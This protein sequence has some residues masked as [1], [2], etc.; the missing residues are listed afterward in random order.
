MCVRSDQAE[1]HQKIWKKNAFMFTVLSMLLMSNSQ[2][3][4]LCFV[5][6]IDS[7]ELVPL[8]FKEHELAC[9]PLS[10]G[11]YL[12]SRHSRLFCG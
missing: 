5:S 1:A 2:K 6:L 10:I 7:L 11:A 12:R 8:L 9:N 4:A 3:Y